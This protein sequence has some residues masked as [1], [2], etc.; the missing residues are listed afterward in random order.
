MRWAVLVVLSLVHPL[1]GA[2]GQR[3]Y[4]LGIAPSVPW[5]PAHVAIALGLWR[6]LGV[7][8][9]AA[10][11]VGTQEHRLAVTHRLVDLALDRIGGLIALQ[12]AGI[13]MT[14]LGECGWVHDQERFAGRQPVGPSAGAT[15]GL[16]SDDPAVLGFLDA[17]LRRRGLGAV[18]M[19]LTVLP[20][21]DLAGEYIRRRLDWLIVPE[22]FASDVLIRGAHR[23]AT[24]ADLPGCMPI[25]IGG[26]TDVIAA[27]PPEDL[28]LIFVG[29]LRAVDWMA[30]P[31]NAAACRAILVERTLVDA[32]DEAAVRAMADANRYHDPA[33]MLERNQPGGPLAL[34]VQHI[35]GLLA[36]TGRLSHPIDVDAM[37][38]TAALRAALA[39]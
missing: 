31:A 12:Q 5:A 9:R 7:T 20:P 8:V 18:D 38:D 26:R 11:H 29:W 14:V 33:V 32:E 28:V 27:I 3:A 35:A 34:H 23:L 6:D 16:P 36:A 24:T 4:R 10:D 22:P 30:D 21:Q 19:T 25:A 17:A 39:R 15:V 1:L 13:P 37:I 2:D